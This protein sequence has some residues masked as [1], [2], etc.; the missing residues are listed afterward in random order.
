MYNVAY[1][2]TTFS[3]LFTMSLT[4]A[5]NV[6]TKLYDDRLILVVGSFYVYKDVKEF[7]ENKDKQEGK[8]ND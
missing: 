8:C 6:A 1:D 5:L 3:R 2:I 7:L 4:E